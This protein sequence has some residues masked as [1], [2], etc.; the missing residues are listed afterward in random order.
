VAVLR[1]CHGPDKVS[2][3][4]SPSI[5]ENNFFILEVYIMLLL[6]DVFLQ[7]VYVDIELCLISYNTS[8]YV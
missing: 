4:L 6:M 1:I 8:K 2:L 5:T 3:S 7:S